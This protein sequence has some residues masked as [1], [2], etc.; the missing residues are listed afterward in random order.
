MNNFNLPYKKKR[1]INITY[2][3]KIEGLKRRD[4]GDYRLYI[5]IILNFRLI[6][7]KVSNMRYDLILNRFEALSLI[8]SI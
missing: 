7:L 5:R 2:M 6:P 1:E 3:Q 8:N 4:K